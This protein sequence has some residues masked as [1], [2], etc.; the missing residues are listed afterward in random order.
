[1][2]QQCTTP[3]KGPYREGEANLTILI[4]LNVIDCFIRVPQSF[5]YK[6]IP[7]QVTEETASC[8][9]ATAYVE[10]M[11]YRGSQRYVHVARCCTWLA[12]SMSWSEAMLNSETIKPITVS[13]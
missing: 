3:I 5:T 12:K 6:F 2:I 10:K 4:E 13:H 11:G 8:T 9:Y 1:M 7:I